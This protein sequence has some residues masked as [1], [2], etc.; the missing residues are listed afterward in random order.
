MG[1]SPMRMVPYMGTVRM[2]LN[3]EVRAKWVWWENTLNP[4]YRRGGSYP[5][6]MYSPKKD[7][8]SLW[9]GLPIYLWILLCIAVG[10]IG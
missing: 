4:A 1:R 7:L 6:E 5:V 2:G 9:W 3:D 8:L 10:G